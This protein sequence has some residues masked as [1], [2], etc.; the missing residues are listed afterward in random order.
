MAHFELVSSSSRADSR[1]SEDNPDGTTSGSEA[2]D[3]ETIPGD[4]PP[5]LLQ[6]QQR[7]P[8]PPPPEASAAEA[9]GREREVRDLV[10]AEFEARM[11]GKK[12]GKSAK[13]SSS[14]SS[15]A[16]KQG[17]AKSGGKS[18]SKSKSKSK[19]VATKSAAAIAKYRKLATSMLAI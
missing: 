9:S 19:G 6:E 17:K 5:P 3:L 7:P 15:G 11:P 14:S 1:E 4:E 12:G 18:K 10:A 8:S 16:K 13:K 2:E